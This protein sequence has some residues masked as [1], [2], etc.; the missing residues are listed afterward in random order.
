M[1]TRRKAFTAVELLIVI[2][3][4]VL[5]AGLV[6]WGLKSSSEMGAKNSTNTTLANLSSMLE[7]LN[8]KNKLAGFENPPP[9]PPV[10][11]ESPIYPRDLTTKPPT[12][13]IEPPGRVS[14][15]S[16]SIDRTSSEAVLRTVVV[17]R[18]LNSIP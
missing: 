9:G 3:I 14:N 13:G 1:L 16:S 18:R 7:E 2:G 10:P 8:R 15:E 5:L 11:P 6:V 17:I 12:G 4:L